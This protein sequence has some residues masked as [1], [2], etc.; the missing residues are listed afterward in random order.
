MDVAERIAWK[1]VKSDQ[2]I[3]V[4][5]A[6]VKGS[7]YDVYR[8]ETTVDATLSALVAINSDAAYMHHWME[9]M[10]SNVKVSGDEKCYVTHAKTKVPWPAKNRDAVVET[11]IE[12]NPDTLQ[13]TMKFHSRDNLVPKSKDYER[14]NLVRGFWQFT[15][16][17][18][19]KTQLTYQNHAEAGGMIPGW[20]ANTFGVDVPFKSVRN[21][22]KEINSSRYRDACVAF[23]TEP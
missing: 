9:A 7:D 5:Q 15:P 12:Q 21:M 13:V 1:L 18:K 10:E 6:P 23:I 4:F 17:G 22:L 11:R 8:L 3:K 14:V 20:I 2:G 16:L 19:G